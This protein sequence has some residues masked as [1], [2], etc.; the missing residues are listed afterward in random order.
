MT[1]YSVVAN[2]IDLFVNGERMSFAGGTVLDLIAELE[3]DLRK[4]AIEHNHQIVPRS[5]FTYVVLA[6]GDQIEIV[7]FIGG[8]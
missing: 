2:E 5:V 4:V 7:H 6:D 1:P 8:G 3:L